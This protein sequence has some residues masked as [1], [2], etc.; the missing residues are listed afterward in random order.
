MTVQTVVDGGHGDKNTVE[1]CRIYAQIRVADV[2]FLR[3]LM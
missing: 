3:P 1:N 2:T